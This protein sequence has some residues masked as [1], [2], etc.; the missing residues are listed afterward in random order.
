MQKEASNQLFQG[1]IF[2]PKFVFLELRVRLTMLWFP[3][4]VVLALK[5]VS[6]GSDRIDAVIVDAIHIFTMRVYLHGSLCFELMVQE[7]IGILIGN[8]YVCKLSA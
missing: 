2:V 3:V 5:F 4:E 7:R 1:T 6:S 8:I